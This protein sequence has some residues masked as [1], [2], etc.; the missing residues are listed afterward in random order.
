M[1]EPTDG[2]RKHPH[3][4]GVGPWKMRC[5]KLVGR[6]VARAPSSSKKNAYNTMPTHRRVQRQAIARLHQMA[7]LDFNGPQLI[8]SVFQ[9]LHQL[10]DFDYGGYFYPGSD[11]DLE[12]FMEAP[13]M[14]A[15]MPTYFDNQLLESERKVVSRSARFFSEAVRYEYGPQMLDR[16]IKVPWSEFQ[17][18]DFYNV[19]VRPADVM[20]CVSLVLRTSQGGGIGA[21]KLYRAV[22][23]PR[24]Q[25]EEIAVLAQIEP[26]L[27]RA[28]QYGEMDAED[29][30]VQDSALLIA[31]PMGRLL[32]LSPEAEVL[33][34]LA[35]GPR[36]RSRTELPP[37]LQLLLQRLQWSCAN[38]SMPALPQMD[39]RNASGWFSLRA[40]PLAAASG[41]GAAVG[42]H[43]TRRLARVAQLLPALQALDLPQRQHEL[44]YW[45]ARGLSE[46]QI[47]LR[48]GVSANT[49]VYHRRQLYMRL[50][51]HNRKEL[52]ARI[53]CGAQPDR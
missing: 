46:P 50:V 51:V 53:G 9:E 37:A 4:P 52:I 18:S 17:R 38:G 34:A 27:A 13:H 23:S 45:L 20:D 35:F 12:V 16:L 32:W 33:M 42:I 29:S 15:L 10:I 36:W 3:P 1:N 26:Y 24:F 6:A 22:S 30:V 39:L 19:V 5:E 7:C 14:R 2:N 43:I 31:T 40:T 47:A 49:L 11:G 25:R 28:L 8:A 44:A 48:M 21:I 41:E